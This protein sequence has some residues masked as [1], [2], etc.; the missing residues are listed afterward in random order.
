MENGERIP[1]VPKIDS[2]YEFEAD[3]MRDLT[4]FWVGGFRSLLIEGDPSAGKSSL[5]E[6]WHARLNVPLYKVAC[7]PTTENYRLIGQFL[8]TSD[9]TLRWH[10]GP[11]TRACRE[12]T[13]V[14]LD[15]YNTLDAGEA[16]ALNLVLEGNSFTIPETGE[17][18]EPART[19]RFFATQNSVDSAT[20][21]AGRN[22]QDV[23]NED[24]FFYME[25]DYLRPDLEES[26]VL[27]S[28]LAGSIPKSTAE[29]IAKLTVSIATKVRAA[30]RQGVDAMEK[31]LSTRAV[32]RWAKL[33]AMYQ[34]VFK[35]KGRSGIHYAI[36]R[37]VKMPASMTL[38]V[39][40]LITAETGFDENLQT[41]Q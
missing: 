1:N 39:S 12:G 17:T 14:L 24:R 21:V 37:A 18:I 11:V 8:P 34:P 27:R 2:Y 15:E 30:F 9:G 3:R 20:A 19:T 33:T 26:L 28:L 22:I 38:A 6:Q 41:A 31:P 40:D 32:L 29:T 35:V 16:T 25:V 4:M 5:I 36:R 7:T 23:A 10:D 13:S